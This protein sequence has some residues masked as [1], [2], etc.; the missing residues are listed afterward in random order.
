MNKNNEFVLFDL[1][2]LGKLTNGKFLERINRFVGKIKVNNQ[3][4]TCHIADTGRLKELLTYGSDI[5]LLKNP[6]NLKT[7]YKLITVKK[8]DELILLNTS[9]HSK[10][11]EEAIKYG[12][13]GYIPQSIK[14][15]VQFN[16]SRLD[17]LVNNDTYIELKGCNLTINNTCLFPDAP[18]T[19]GKRHIEELILA[20]NRGYKS[21]ILIMALRDCDCFLPNKE[22][23]PEFYN[24]F[25]LALKTGVKPIIFKV[26]IDNNKKIILDTT[27]N[28]C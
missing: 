14:R 24:L 7:D 1:N 8:D 2:S 9:F 25:F 12:I 17:Y 16:K 20:K 4:K 15:E 13:L 28:L 26:K 23:D 27:I 22:T 3:V 10:I 19:R 18:T 6:A 5:L 21:I 11:A